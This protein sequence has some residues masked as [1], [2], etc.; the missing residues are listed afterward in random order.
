[1]DQRHGEVKNKVAVPFEE[2]HLPQ[3]VEQ[4]EV[5]NPTEHRGGP[6]CGV[7]LNHDFFA[8]QMTVY[9]PISVREEQICQVKRTGDVREYLLLLVGHGAFRPL[10]K[11]VRN[12]QPDEAT[13]MCV[14]V[15]KS[16]TT[17]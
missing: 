5:N 17:L 6:T 9:F 8:P 10:V 1:M 12:E 14:S 2:K 16:K 11:V 13:K 4:R 7:R 3:L 15:S